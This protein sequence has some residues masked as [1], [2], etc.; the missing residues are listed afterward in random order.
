MVEAVKDLG[1]VV[2]VAPAQPQSAK[3]WGITITEP[4]YM[5]KVNTFGDDI[6]AYEGTGTPAD[7]VKLAKAILFKVKNLIS[8]YQELIM[9]LML[10]LILF[11]L[12]QYPELKKQVWKV[13]N[14]SLF[15]Y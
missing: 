15:L 5:R 13:F 8:V 3:G 2:V 7:C 9:V 10:L 4:L 11:I 14:Q 6:E 1:R 12:E